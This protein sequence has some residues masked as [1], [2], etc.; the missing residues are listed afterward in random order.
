[1]KVIRIDKLGWHSPVKFKSKK[2]LRQNLADYH[3]INNEDCNSDYETKYDKMSLKDLLEYVNWQM[4][5][6]TNA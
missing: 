1:M 6:E 5:E 3:S 2:D 4:E